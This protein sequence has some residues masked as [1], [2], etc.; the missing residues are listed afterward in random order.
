MTYNLDISLHIVS[1]IDLFLN[2]LLLQLYTV[3]IL[4]IFISSICVII[5][6]LSVGRESWHY[7]GRQEPDCKA[8]QGG[9]GQGHLGED[10]VRYLYSEVEIIAPEPPFFGWSGSVS[11]CK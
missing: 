6:F 9:E 11:T 10:Q 2:F 7:R 3:K 4:F 8:E 5:K 1:Y